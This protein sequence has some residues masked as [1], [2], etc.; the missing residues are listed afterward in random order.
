LASIGELARQ[1]GH[2]LRNPLSGIKNGAY[3]LRKKGAACSDADRNYMLHII[4][5]AVE[6]TNRIINDL[7]EYSSELHLDLRKCSFQFIISQVLS[8]IKIP[9]NIQVI[10]NNEDCLFIADDLKLER[11]FSII[12]KNAIDAMPKGGTLTIRSF[13]D[14]SK[15]KFQFTDSGVGIPEEVL[16]KIFSPLNTTKAKGMGFSLA[17]CKRIVDAHEGRIAVESKV[18]VGTTFT[19]TLP[20]KPELEF[21]VNSDWLVIPE[22]IYP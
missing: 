18:N 1:V 8:K 5:N 20:A 3:Y 9:T 6:D 14:D 7:L 4:D 22:K 17:I 10:N 2:D 11:V 21:E 16:G 13:K 15:V 19:I 12:V